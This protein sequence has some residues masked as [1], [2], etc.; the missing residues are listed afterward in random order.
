MVD[1]TEHEKRADHRHQENRPNA[2]LRHAPP[3]RFNPAM[4]I[5]TV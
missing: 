4:P 1:A 2:I 3:L 5:P